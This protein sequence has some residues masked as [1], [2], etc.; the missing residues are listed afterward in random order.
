ML[1]SSIRK[2]ILAKVTESSPALQKAQGINEVKEAQHPDK[3][4][5]FRHQLKKLKAFEAKIKKDDVDFEEADWKAFEA[6][7]KPQTTGDML[8]SMFERREQRAKQEADEKRKL[9]EQVF[10]KIDF[11]KIGRL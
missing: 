1:D 4:F 6:F 5:E 8:G 10:S 9:R 11:N 3:I 2:A 7:A